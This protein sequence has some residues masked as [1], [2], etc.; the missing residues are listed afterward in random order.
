MENQF[1]K[2]RLEKLKEL[3]TP[4]GLFL[5]S[6]C[7]GTGYDKVW[8]RDNF[9]TALAFEEAEDWETVEQ[10]YHGL[11]NIFLKHEAKID[12]AIENKL[13]HAWQYIHA[14]YNPVTLEEFHDEWGNKQ[15]DAIGAIL[16]GIGSLEEK[17]HSVLRN[18]GDQRIL[19]KLVKY[20]DAIEYWRCPDN[21][22][23][24]EHQELHASSIAAC[25]AGLNMVADMVVIPEGL[26]ERGMETLEFQLL[27]RESQSKFA[28]MAQLS[29]MYPYGMV[30]DEHIA[31]GLRN[32]EY[33]LMRGRGMIRYK[34][35][36]YYN[37]DAYGGMEAEW[38][39]GPSW[40]SVIY[41]SIGDY[42]NA[43]RYL[44]MAD[45][46]LHNDM[47]PELYLSGQAEPNDNVSLAWAEAMYIIA[48]IRLE[49]NQ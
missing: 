29:L 13:E 14:R 31:G 28:D 24:E 25:V 1:I 45:G 2:Q 27:P 37:T 15:H 3:Q 48:N 47:M 4:S 46:L 23:W 42:V 36:K 19:E 12:W 44:N 26:V 10:I 11:L 20:L 40:L 33:Y 9:Y 18:D 32:L 39:M 21:G 38:T 43:R 34:G 8:L 22:M 7:E 30:E 5:A 35:D 49:K 17:G 16:F 41:S 6:K